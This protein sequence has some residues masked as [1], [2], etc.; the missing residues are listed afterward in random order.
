MY[1]YVFANNTNWNSSPQ[2]SKQTT[3]FIVCLLRWAVKQERFDNIGQWKHTVVDNSDWHKLAL[4][5]P[6]RPDGEINDKYDWPM[7]GFLLPYA[8]PIRTK[9]LSDKSTKDYGELYLICFLSTMIHSLLYWPG[10]R[11]YIYLNIAQQQDVKYLYK[12]RYYEQ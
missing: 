10:F 4:S 3:G 8:P 7:E 12:Y 2:R 9:A 5:W 1:C 11:C 6:T